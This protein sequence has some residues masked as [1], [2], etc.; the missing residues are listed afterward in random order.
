MNWAHTHRGYE[1]TVGC[2]TVILEVYHSEA[3]VRVEA[4]R[5]WT[6]VWIAKASLRTFKKLALEEL[7]RFVLQ[8]REDADDAL[9]ELEAR[10]RRVL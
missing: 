1:K 6:K 9:R 7:K 4:K 10:R 5:A 3:V 8:L 2:F